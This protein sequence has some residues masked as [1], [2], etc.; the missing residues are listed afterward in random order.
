MTLV[1]IGKA[2][3]LEGWHSPHLGYRF[4]GCMKIHWHWCF[5]DSKLLHCYFI[6]FPNKPNH[7]TLVVVEVPPVLMQQLDTSPA[8]WLYDWKSLAHHL[9]TESPDKLPSF[10]TAYWVGGVTFKLSFVLKVGLRVS[11]LLI[12]RVD[13]HPKETTIFKIC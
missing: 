8:S 7:P 9:L 2:L 6:S 13:H 10:A 12:P 11:P 5:C 1:F 4:F 3:V